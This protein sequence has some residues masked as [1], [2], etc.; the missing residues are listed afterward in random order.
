MR[1]GHKTIETFR[2]CTWWS[3]WTRVRGPAPAWVVEAFKS[4][5]GRQAC[6]I[7]RSGVEGAS[8][9]F[10]FPATESPRSALPSAT[11]RG[12]CLLRRLPVRALVLPA[13][14]YPRGS[15]PARPS[16]SRTSQ[17]AQVEEPVKRSHPALRHPTRHR[18]AEEFDHHRMWECEPADEQITIAE[19]LMSRCVFGYGILH[20]AIGKRSPLLPHR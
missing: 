9:L 2:L 13:A 14:F 10:N 3:P 4:E 1:L 20:R 15:R 5:C 7:L 6:T 19:C 12:R 17:E 8:I 16:M 18:R 11:D